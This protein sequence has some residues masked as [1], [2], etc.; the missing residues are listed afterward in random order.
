MKN[1][2]TELILN[3]KIL[4]FVS[5]PG[6]YTGNE[7][8]IIIKDAE[9]AA[10][11]VALAFPEVYEIG[12][13]YMGFEMLYHIL[14]Q[15]TDVWAERVYAPWPDME[16]RMR[17]EALQLFSLESFTP[18]NQYDIIGFTLQYELTYTNILNMLN[19]SAIPIWQKERDERHPLIIGGGPCTANPEP[20]ADFFDAIF[21]GDGEEGFVELCNF[22]QSAKKR[23]L[24]RQEMLT[25]LAKISGVYIPALY[26]VSYDN[27]N[28]FRTISPLDDA[29][30]ERITSRITSELKNAWYP[31]KPIVPLIEVAHDRLAA[32]VMRGCTQGCRYCNAGMTYRPRRERPADDIINHSLRA[33]KNSGYS[34]LSFSSLSISDYSQLS[35]IMQKT[36]A[37]FESRNINV[38]FPSMRLDSFSEEIARFASSVRKSGFTFAPEAGSERLRRV[39]NKNISDTD[40]YK[41]LEIAL[42]NGWKHL[43]FYFMIGLPTETKEDVEDIVRLIERALE[44]AKPFGKVRF[45][46]SISPFSPKAHTPFQWARQNTKDELLEKIAILKN[47]F[48][49]IRQVN[50]SWR[51]PEVSM[52]ECILGRA[53]RS[54]AKA[55]WL[56]WKNGA[57]FDGW[58]D[59]FKFRVW[60]QA[61]AEANLKIPE[62]T[63]AIPE[64]QALPWDFID[65]GVFKKFLL[66]EWEKA[67]QEKTTADC[68]EKFCYGCGIQTRKTFDDFGLCHYDKVRKSLSGSLTEDLRKSDMVHGKEKQADQSAEAIPPLKYRLQFTKRDYAIYLSHLDI[69]RNFERAFRR[70]DVPLLYSQGFNPHPR[71]SFGP[72]ISLGFS[73]EAEYVDVQIAGNFEGD[74]A[75]AVNP[76]LPEGLR[77]IQSAAI[78]GKAVSLNAVINAAEY[79]VFVNNPEFSSDTMNEAINRLMQSDKLI[80]QRRVKSKMKT[81][82]IR[83]YIRSVKMNRDN[84]IIKSQKIADRT[85]RVNEILRFLFDEDSLQNTQI[86]IH[87]NK[88]LIL[89]NGIEK[90]PMDLLLS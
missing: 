63:E 52:L 2:N 49:R 23:G 42:R 59:L 7:H 14:N 11:R 46:V 66:K 85:V 16:E 83:P 74:L 47:Q 55:I 22:V 12:M 21:I 39:I 73:S 89:Q 88:Q 26:S 4:P 61:F 65:K 10:L 54:A 60:E 70:A 90:T 58:T 67:Q 79:L 29:A 51:D 82:D 1:R 50:L 17:K 19:L 80:I 87:R 53:N 24:T 45:N 32:E 69:I 37:V 62:M 78:N 34:K 84:L 71:L 56:A 43:K 9:S 75:G 44:I 3:H 40:L 30:P 13:S 48:H 86:S 77:I 20:V 35:E 36:Q 64:D 5:K 81:I 8:N 31:E 76:H 57:T 68:K 27:R 72:P 33:L 41:S 25:G 15:Q 28:N 6:R 38:S 18:L